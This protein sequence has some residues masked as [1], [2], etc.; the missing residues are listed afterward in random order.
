M[1]NSRCKWP[2][3]TLGYFP[4]TSKAQCST[5]AAQVPTVLDACND[6]KVCGEKICIQ[7]KSA[8]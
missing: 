6:E 8:R 1:L 4:V 7:T 5:S 2:E 3:K